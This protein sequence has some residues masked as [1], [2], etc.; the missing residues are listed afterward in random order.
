MPVASGSQRNG[1]ADIDGDDSGIGGATN[2]ES[3]SDS[4]T[5]QPGHGMDCADP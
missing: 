2:W 4:R 5:Q 3:N 1:A